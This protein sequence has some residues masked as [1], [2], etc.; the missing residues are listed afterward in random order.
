MS[1]H[2]SFAIPL[3]LWHLVIQRRGRRFDTTFK[4]I[5]NK[6]K[7]LT[8]QWS[9]QNFLF[10]VASEQDN[11]SK[12]NL[13]WNPCVYL[14]LN[15]AGA[16]LGEENYHVHLCLQWELHESYIFC[17]KQTFPV[18]FPH[19]TWAGRSWTSIAF[20]WLKQQSSRDPQFQQA[21]GT[22]V[23]Y[24]IVSRTFVFI[25]GK[26]DKLMTCG[27]VWIIEAQLSPVY[28]DN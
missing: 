14:F 7:C 23:G 6:K 11:N 27:F 2:I 3:T 18:C 16:T 15:S 12:P 22:Q 28:C 20:S 9:V 1:P 24:L 21:I 4:R 10:L 17:W 5:L 13:Y 19:I 25:T 8:L 26:C